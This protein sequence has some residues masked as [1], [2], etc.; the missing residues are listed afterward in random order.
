MPM[1]QRVLGDA[2]IPED[3]RDGRTLAK[4]IA[5]T[6]PTKVN[7]TSIRDNAQLPGLRE[8][9]RVKAACRFLVEAGWLVEPD[10][11]VRTGRPRG[12]YVVNP[13]LWD[14]VPWS[15]S[16]EEEVSA[17]RVPLSSTGFS[18]FSGFSG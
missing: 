7:V 17:W 15:V 9:K 16:Q 2:S 5:D 14:L 6:R 4:W 12:D 10:R 18:G 1:Q 8:S 11:E 13:M 3:E